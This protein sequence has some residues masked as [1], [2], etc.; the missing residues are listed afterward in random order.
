M[1]A[2]SA[3]TDSRISTGHCGS[4]K[5]LSDKI[6][7]DRLDALR[8][9]ER[10]VQRQLVLSIA[11]VERRHPECV[12]LSEAFTRPK[13]M[14][15]L[16][17]LGFDQSYTDFT[18]RNTSWELEEYLPEITRPPVSHFFRPN[19]FANTPDILHAF[20]QPYYGS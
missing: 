12:F 15:A 6:L 3:P 13:L 19:F 18:W 10:E 9:S 8:G 14:Y 16:A 11:E 1:I 5:D 17:K 7:L 20:L 4:L 2:T